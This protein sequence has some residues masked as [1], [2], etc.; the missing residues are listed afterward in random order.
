SDDNYGEDEWVS[1]L[2]KE[3]NPQNARLKWSLTGEKSKK[4][5]GRYGTYTLTYKI[6]GGTETEITLPSTSFEVS[7]DVYVLNLGSL[8]KNDTVKFHI[9][10]YINRCA[11]PNNVTWAVTLEYC[12]GHS[13]EHVEAKAATC[14]VKGNKEYWYCSKCDKHFANAECTTV[15]TEWEISALG[16]KATHNVKKDATCTENGNIEYWHCS[17]CDLNYSDE[18]CTNQITGSVVIPATHHANKQLM[19]YKAPTAD[20]QGNIEY[21][22]CPDCEKNFEDNGCTKEIAGT[23]YILAKL[24]NVLHIDFTGTSTPIENEHYLDA[25]EIGFTEDGGITLTIDNKTV[26]YPDSII[27]E[28]SFFNG[29][30][31]VTI[32]ANEDPG[33][34][35][36]YSTFYSS[37]ESY[38]VPEG[39][40]AYRGEIST[41]GKKLNLTSVEGGVMSRGEGYILKGTTNSRNMNVTENAD[42]GNTGN[43]LLGTDVAIA[44]LGANDYALSL[45]QNGVGF[46]LWNGKEIGANKAY[47]TLSESNPAK[48][49][50]F[51]FNEEPSGIEETVE[52]HNLSTSQPYNLNGMRVNDNYKGI[53]IK[54]N[55]KYVVR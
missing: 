17:N 26:T 24:L 55:K 3:A 9:K 29:T 4:N 47:L 39:F 28:V 5:N 53:V 35:V 2:V 23:D 6:N 51:E 41:D 54:N 48:S 10:N 13:I 14:T 40:T 7:P 22:H 15:M 36:Y 46:Y 45:G 52:S 32:S 19:P 27:N 30:P 1:F 18:A 25:T 33:K 38:A 8:N 43:V 37:L 31:K 21:W 34:G 16:H 50:I 20:A 42:G 12:P 11:T 44:K 49:L